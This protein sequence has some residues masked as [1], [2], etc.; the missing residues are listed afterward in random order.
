MFLYGP[1]YFFEIKNC[2]FIVP[3]FTCVRVNQSPIPDVLFRVNSDYLLEGSGRGKCNMSCVGAEE[4]V[5]DPAEIL[6]N[7]GWSI[8]GLNI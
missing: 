6:K 4:D 8:L 7:Q 2:G 3:D 1:K 5:Y